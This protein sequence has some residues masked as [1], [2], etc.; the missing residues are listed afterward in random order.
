MVEKM[1]VTSFC[2]HA[3]GGFFLLLHLL[4]NSAHGIADARY[5]IT[6]SSVTTRYPAS[7]KMSA[8]SA[9]GDVEPEFVTNPQL[10]R[11]QD[12]STS[13]EVLQNATLAVDSLTSGVDEIDIIVNRKPPLKKRSE[14]IYSNI[15]S[16]LYN[17]PLVVDGSGDDVVGSDY[18]EVEN[19]SFYSNIRY[20]YDE[21]TDSEDVQEAKSTI[22]SRIADAV[23][24]GDAGI[25][26]GSRVGDVTNKRP[27]LISSSSSSLSPVS[28]S[29]SVPVSSSYE[30]AAMSE[31]VLAA[32]AI[33]S[34]PVSDAD[35]DAD[36]VSVADMREGE[37]GE[38]EGGE[39]LIA[40]VANK[41]PPLRRTSPLLVDGFSMRPQ[42]KTNTNINTETDTDTDGSALS[43]IYSNIYSGLYNQPLVVDGSDDGDGDDDEVENTSFYSNIRYTYDEDTDS[44]D[45]QEAKSTIPSRIT[46][47]PVES[48]EIIL[49]NARPPLVVRDVLPSTLGPES[50]HDTAQTNAVGG[51]EETDVYGKESSETLNDSAEVFLDSSPTPTQGDMEVD[52]ELNSEILTDMKTVYND[53]THT[54]YTVSSIPCVGSD[55]EEM[56]LVGESVV[57]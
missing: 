11:S 55:S 30:T 14:T 9:V 4:C 13:A 36:A 10:Y 29:V 34:V 54:S 19:T 40:A 37:D 16:G 35:A 7:Y 43:E 3:V 39:V 17:Q 41:R 24:S 32:E 56:Q 46:E 33:V 26:V 49:A 2:H 21:D 8:L 22:P 18:D 53:S 5:K 28:V 31:S 15:Y 42:P 38:R 23:M 12:N 51:A 48:G 50:S 44:E 47:S 52:L 27:P 1:A 25:G 45:V 6:L 57:I 20:T